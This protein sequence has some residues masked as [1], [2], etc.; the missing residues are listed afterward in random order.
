MEHVPN[1]LVVENQD[2]LKENNVSRINHGRLRQPGV[3]EITRAR[4]YVGPAP[5]RAVCPSCVW[6][7]QHQ[8]ESTQNW[9]LPRMGHEVVG[10]YLDCLPLNNIFQGCVHQIIIKSVCKRKV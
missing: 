4:C 10:G 9:H 6:G 3:K 8:P 2:P 1:V 7:Y 5:H